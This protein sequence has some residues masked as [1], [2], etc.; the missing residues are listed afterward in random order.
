MSTLGHWFGW[1]AGGYLVLSGAASGDGAYGARREGSARPVRV[2][3]EADFLADEK[4]FA[5]DEKRLDAAAAAQEAEEGP[6]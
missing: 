4:R 5:E 2:G 6:S 1:G 3:T